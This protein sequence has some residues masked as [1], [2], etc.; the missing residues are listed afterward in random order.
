MSKQPAWYETQLIKDMMGLMG[1]RAVRGITSNFF[2]PKIYQGTAA[3]LSVSGHLA[4]MLE[5]NERRAFIITD[6]FTKKYSKKVT[7]MLDLIEMEYK[8]WSN[9]E[10]EVPLSTIE[11]GTRVCE[12]FKPTVIIAIGGGSV[13]D[14]AKIIM[15][16][17]EKPDQN[18]FLILPI[19]TALGLRKKLKYFIA[20]PTTSGTGS[21]ATQAAVLTDTNRDP[22]KKLEIMS[23]ELVPDFAILDTDFVKDMPPNLTKGTGLDALAHA[24]GSYVSNWGNPFIDAINLTAIKE[25]LKYLPRAYKYGSRDIEARDHMQMAAL[26]AG[27]GFG[28]TIPGIEHSL[29]HSFGKIFKVHHGLCV[30]LFLPYSVAFQAKVT[31]RWIPLCPIFGVETDNKSSGVLLKEFIKSLNNFIHSVEGPTC[32]KDLK[33][34][35][36][37]EKEYNKKLELLAEYANEDAISLSSFR[38][39]NKN[40]YKKIFEYAWEGKLID[41]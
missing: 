1:G 36:I 32:I 5:A 15:V 10:P 14:A 24:I 23:A 35:S 13:I 2:S 6:Q 8:I 17:Y 26:L 29:G 30:G 28:N 39:V 33:E 40:V 3:L 31:E 11:E 37:D 22:P 16:K 9:V 12:E 34:P 38:A 20:I 7:D 21:E 25:V 19:F 18:L 41:F 27:L 4:S